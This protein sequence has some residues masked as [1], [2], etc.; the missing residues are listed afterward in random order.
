MILLIENGRFG[1]QL[2]QINYAFKIR[3]KNEIIYLVGFDDIKKIL[4][5]KTYIKYIPNKSIIGKFIIN[6]R[7]YLTKLYKHLR[8]GL[9]ILEN[10]KEKIEYH[11]GFIP[12][13]RF[14]S[15]FFQNPDFIN[16]AF[17]NSINK[18]NVYAKKAEKKIL[19]L[20]KKHNRIIFIHYRAT[21]FMMWPNKKSPAIVPL[22]WYARCLK[23]FYGFKTKLLVFSD[24]NFSLKKYTNR[25]YVNEK[26]HYLVDF[27][28]MV[29]CDHGILSPSTFSWWA[30]YFLRKKKNNSIIIAPKYWAGH[31]MNVSYPKFL[32]KINYKY[33]KV[34][35]LDYINQ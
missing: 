34:N 8:I 31:R 11:K 33:I 17:I 12:K 15:G 18:D 20:K 27:F 9:L 4:K 35:K 22:N 23:K 14:L 7:Y 19:L 32:D 24:S 2:F 26:N 10:K 13:V 5:E 21:D 29:N 28:M 6:Y 25:R 3:K 30:A 1:N 16:S